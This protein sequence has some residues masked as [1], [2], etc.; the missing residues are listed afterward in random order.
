[1]SATF[2]KLLLLGKKE[3]YANNVLKSSVELE[4]RKEFYTSYRDITEWNKLL[5]NGVIRI[6]VK[7][8]KILTNYLIIDD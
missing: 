6:L 1:M 2:L 3:Y 5:I 4:C 8:D 7:D